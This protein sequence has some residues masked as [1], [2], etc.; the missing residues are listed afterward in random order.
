V[1]AAL[2]L[3][4]G[5]I[6]GAAALVATPVLTKIAGRDSGWLRSRAH[7]PLSVVGI[8]AAVTLAT[9]PVEMLAYAV[10]ALACAFL[11][12]VDLAVHRLPDIIVGPTAAAL[13]GL[14]ALAAVLDGELG[15]WGRSLLAGLVLFGL[16]Y[17]LA[18]LRRSGLGFGD[19][20]LAGLLGLF[21]GWLGWPQVLA[22]TVA[23]FALGGMW[24]AVLLVSRRSG[25]GGSYPYGPWMVL[26]AALGA[27][28][29]AV[30]A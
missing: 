28:W 12:V 5:V 21:L 27:A 11:V 8:V 13:G 10:L 22:G 6:G 7:V 3:A 23:A 20:K 17:A 16:Y 9:N 26:G 18:L 2:A 19:V 24:A 29:G 14:L 4:A 30:A 15:R 1:L 25:R